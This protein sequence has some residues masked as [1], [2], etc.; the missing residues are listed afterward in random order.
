M[1][2]TKKKTKAKI[3]R[4]RIEFDL[5]EI[6]KLGALGCTYEEMGA[7]MGISHEVITDRMANDLAFS[8]AYK[9]GLGKLKLSLRRRQITVAQGDEAKKINPNPAMLIWLGKQYLGQTEKIESVGADAG[10]NMAAVMEVIRGWKKKIANGS[11]R[12][13]HSRATG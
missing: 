6:E 9:S 13:R 11:T 2:E 8:T 12:P 10:E 4:P 7:W 5:T 1:A 3:G